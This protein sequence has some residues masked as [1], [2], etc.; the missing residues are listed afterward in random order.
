MTLG[1]RELACSDLEGIN[2]LPETLDYMSVID[3][4]IDQTIVDISCYLLSLV[5]LS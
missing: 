3:G 2:V 1:M 5:Y 4:H